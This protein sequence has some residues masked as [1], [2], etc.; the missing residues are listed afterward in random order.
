MANTNIIPEFPK[1]RYNRLEKY[2]EIRN[3]FNF[4]ILLQLLIRLF[5]KVNDLKLKH[6]TNG[7]T[8]GEQ[9]E[10]ESGNSN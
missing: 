1:S 5:V 6:G 10:T 8:A 4:P 2:F 9:V 3:I 7:Y